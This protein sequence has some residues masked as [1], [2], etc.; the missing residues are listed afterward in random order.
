VGLLVA[1]LWGCG[2]ELHRTCERADE[3][4]LLRGVSVEECTE[5]SERRAEDLND[6]EATDLDTMLDDCLDWESCDAFQ[7]CLNDADH[8]KPD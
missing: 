7:E 2:S 3:C 1:S 5:N 6:D 4:N 8:F